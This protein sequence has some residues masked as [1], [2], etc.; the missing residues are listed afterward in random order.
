MRMK[1]KRME[2]ASKTNQERREEGS[3]SEYLSLCRRA[4]HEMISISSLNLHAN[5]A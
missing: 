3:K 2:N 1:S 4:R 5:K